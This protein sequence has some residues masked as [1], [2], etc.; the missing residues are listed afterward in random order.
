MDYTK[1]YYHSSSEK[2]EVGEIVSIDNF[3][4]DV[5]NYHKTHD[6]QAEL[7]NRTLIIGYWLNINKKRSNYDLNNKCIFSH[8]NNIHI[9][10]G[11][12]NL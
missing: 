5:C 12:E 11:C 1:D 9:I 6:E 7:I 3:Y 8:T 2:Y 4:G 10:F